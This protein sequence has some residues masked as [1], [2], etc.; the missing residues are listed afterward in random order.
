MVRKAAF[1]TIIVIDATNAK[2]RDAERLLNDPDSR[3]KE[4]ATKVLCEDSAAAAANVSTFMTMLRGSNYSLRMQAIVGL[5]NAGPAAADALPILIQENIGSSFENRKK[6]LAFAAIK[7]IDPT[8]AKTIP[9]L[10]PALNDAFKVRGASELLEHLG[11]PA[12][13]ELAKATR[14]R[15]KLK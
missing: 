14:E 10:Q 8:G 2:Y 6:E 12:C 7:K 11:S 9:L 4:L 13:L 1:E 5:G 3:L 15:W